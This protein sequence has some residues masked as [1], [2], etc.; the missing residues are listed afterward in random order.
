MSTQREPPGGSPPPG[1]DRPGEG[2]GGASGIEAAIDPGVDPPPA[3]DLPPGTAR[4]P[5]APVD[6]RAH[7]D[8]EEQAREAARARFLT[9]CLGGTPRWRPIAGDASFRRYFRVEMG[10]RSWILMD[11]PPDREPCAPF[12]TVARLLRAAGVHAPAVH[13]AAPGSGFLLLEDLG[14]ESY[15]DRL[16]EES[17]DLLYSDAL[18]ALVRMQSRLGDAP[19]PPYDDRALRGEL[20]L[21]PQWFLRRHLGWELDSGLERRLERISGVL[22]ENAREQPRTFVHRDYHSRN[23]LVSEPNPGVIDFQD[24][25]LGPLTYDLVSLFRDVYIRWPEERLEAWLA[26]YRFR[27]RAAGLTVVPPGQDGRILGRWFDLMGV[28]RHLKVAGIFARLCYR[29]GK[30]RYLEDLPLTLAYLREVAARHAELDPLSELL[31]EVVLP[32]RE[33][34]R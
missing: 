26:S 7:E 5:C 1:A 16:D 18:D 8:E 21:F 33:A 25:V 13:E 29:D 12:V 22:L 9:A 17:A 31:A 32:D 3:S 15:L 28:Q 6:P 4:P 27:A 14:T 34:C 19:L 30:P 24:A 10:G 20:A 2:R 23:L 11:A